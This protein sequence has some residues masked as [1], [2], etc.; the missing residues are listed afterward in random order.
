[1]ARTTS[2]P[3]ATTAAA[4]RSIPHPKFKNKSAL[5]VILTT[6]HSGGKFSGKSYATSGGLHGVGISVVNAL[7]DDLVV[8]VARDRKLLHAELFAAA[9]RKGQAQAGAATLQ[10]RRGTTIRFQ[11]TRRSSATRCTFSPTQLYR[12]V[13][14]K[15]YLFRGVEIRWSC[16][17]ELLKDGDD[18]PA[19]DQ[20]HFPDGLRDYLDASHERPPDG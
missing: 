8:E 2:S 19:K 6:L 4:S 17:P 13:R 15:A 11:P 16:D 10:N 3:C 18:T 12:M 20:L 7:S 14:S 5:E 1:M 9:S